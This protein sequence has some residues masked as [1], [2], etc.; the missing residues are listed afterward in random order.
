M[1][2]LR[3]VVYTYAVLELSDGWYQV[4]IRNEINGT[5]TMTGLMS[6]ADAL[7]FLCMIT[8]CHSYVEDVD[9]DTQE[10]NLE[11]VG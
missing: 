4:H 6:K 10:I 9:A 11:D 2:E 7:N 1:T 5:A 8:G 3:E